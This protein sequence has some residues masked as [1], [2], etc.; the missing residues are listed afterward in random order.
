MLSR[1]SRTIAF[2]LVFSIALAGCKKEEGNQECESSCV[3]KLAD[4]VASCEVEVAECL[5]GCAGLDDYDCTWDCEDIEFDCIG[6]FYVCS[7]GCP[8]ASDVVSCSRNCPEDDVD[9]LVACAND[10]VSCAGSDSPYQ[11]SLTCQQETSFCRSQCE[12]LGYE[13][14]EFVQCRTVCGEDSESCLRGCE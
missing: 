11:C 12:T 8:C 13:T 10:Y 1:S 9:C 6:N 4:K 7:G 2:A 14:D 3:G 5:S